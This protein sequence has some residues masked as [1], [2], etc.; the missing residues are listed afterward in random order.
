MASIENMKKRMAKVHSKH[1]K[2]AAKLAALKAQFEAEERAFQ[3]EQ[4]RVNNEWVKAFSTAAEKDDI[5]VNLLDI[6]Q[7]VE[8]VKENISLLV[9]ENAA[10]DSESNSE[11]INQQED[12]NPNSNNE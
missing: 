3:Q 9:D 1:T 5:Q 6:D 2:T 7:L 11:T 8:L 10:A 4:D 12:T